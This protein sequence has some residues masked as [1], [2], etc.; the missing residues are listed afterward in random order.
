MALAKDPSDALQH[1][2][3]A[4]FIWQWL[5]DGDGVRTSERNA[6]LASGLERADEAWRLN[7]SLAEALAIQG[8]IHALSGDTDGRAVELVTEA[9]ERNA[10]LEHAWRPWLDARRK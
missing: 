8:A 3:F 4:R 9:L 5:D 10:N 2:A 1:L 6:A 7:P